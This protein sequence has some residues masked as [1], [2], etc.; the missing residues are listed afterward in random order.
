MHPSSFDKMT[1]F[2]RDYLETRRHEPLV[3]VDLGSLDING[4]YRPLFAEPPWTYKGVD[5]APGQNV[6][7][8]LRDPYHWL[9]FDTAS[10]DVVISGQAFEHIEFFWETMREIARV[11][12]SHGLCCIIAPSSGPEHRFPIDCWRMYPDGLRAVARY[13][14]LEVLE[15]RTQWEDLAQYDA[16]SNVWHDSVLVARKPVEH[17]GKRFRRSLHGWLNRHL[18]ILDHTPETVIQIY[19]S[20][21]GNLSEENSVFGRA[22]HDVWENV[23]IILPKQEQGALLRIDFIGPFRVIDIASIRVKAPVETIFQAENSR[24][25]EAMKVGGDAQRLE[26]SKFFR[27]KITGLDPQLHLPSLAAAGGQPLSVEIRLRVHAQTIPIA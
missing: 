4:S 11:L 16:V 13:S 25:F 9:E 3:I 22:G 18:P 17:F 6:D 26:H 10:V 20:K 27:V 21:N 23:S 8:V 5:L 2:R 19:Y 7:L 15:T 12:K 1:A 24:G 14:G